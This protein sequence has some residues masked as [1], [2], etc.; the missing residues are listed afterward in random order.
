MATSGVLVCAVFSLFNIVL[1]N[2]PVLLWESSKS[3]RINSFPALHRVSR[4]EYQKYILQK[5]HNEQPAPLMAV[6]C[7]ESLS[8]EDFSSQDSQG[9]GYFPQL[10]YITKNAANIEFLPSVQDPIET[11]KQLSQF[12]YSV[13]NI[14]SDKL[15]DLPDGC[16]KILIVTFEEAKMADNRANFLGRHDDKIAEI[17]SQL[18]SKCSH[19]IGC[20]TGQQSSWIEP[21]EISRMRRSAE[22]DASNST[23][24]VGL[25]L[26]S[27]NYQDSK[28]FSLLFSYSFPK[29]INDGKEI[30]VGNGTQY[31]VTGD[32]SKPDD[33]KLVVRYPGKCRLTFNYDNKTSGYWY[34]RTVDFELDSGSGEPIILQPSL[35][36]VAPLDMSFHSGTPV[37]FK[38]GTTTV[39]FSDLQVQPFFLKPGSKAF[40]DA[41]DAV[42]F[43]TPAIW[44]GLFVTFLL[45]L[46][47][48][49]GIS[50]IMDIRTMDQFDDPKGKTITVSATD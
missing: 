18:L 41:V 25:T 35:D 44:S 28:G 4:E 49:W 6:F 10:Q 32:N 11:T 33:I 12:G 37:T 46:I 38:N 2:V 47:F 20:L 31:V 9:Q 39:T 45:A 24:S 23:S 15:A 21:E 13:I 8:I 1:G 5:V 17:Y 19:V 26:K 42:E 50:M 29:I 16:G 48:T 30:D 14:D 22:E 34:L 27:A 7:E 36:I 40:S 3:D 43:F